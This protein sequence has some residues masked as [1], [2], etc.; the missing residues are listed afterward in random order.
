MG[1]LGLIE[2]RILSAQICMY[3]NVHADQCGSPICNEV[4]GR[5]LKS[6][7]VRL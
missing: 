2:V 7:E 6:V 1:L 3:K 4:N 5:A